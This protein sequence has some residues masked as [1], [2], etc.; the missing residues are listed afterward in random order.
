MSS[1]LE[2]NTKNAFDLLQ[3]LYF[4]ISYLIRETEGLLGQHDMIILRPSGY[5]ITTRTSTGLEPANVEYWFPRTVTTFFCPNEMTELSRGQTNTPF[6]ES[7]RV[8]VLHLDLHNEHIEAPTVFAACIRNIRTK[9]NHAKFEH[10]LWV[11]PQHGRKL[12]ESPPTISYED[13]NCSFVG[14]F[15]EAPLFSVSS[16]EKIGE[17][18]VDP[19]LE[20]YR[21]VS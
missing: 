4:E 15:V 8:L 10:L 19:M 21:A 2:T 17:L 1:E 14:D 11:F 6:T 7:L 12:F 3:K 9:K 13:T 5:A 18:L 20:M 16:S